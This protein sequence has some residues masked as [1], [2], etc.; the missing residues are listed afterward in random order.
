MPP[1]R[2]SRLILLGLFCATTV[3]FAQTQTQPLSMQSAP[4]LMAK[5][6]LGDKKGMAVVG[7][8]RD[9]KMSF[10]SA[11]QALP[12]PGAAQPMFEIGSISKVFTGLLL[13]QAVERGELSLSDTLGKLLGDQHKLPAPVAAVTLGQLITHTSCLPR[14]PGDFFNAGIDEGNPYAAYDRERMWRALTAVKLES[15]APCEAVYSNYGVALVGELLSA[16]YNKPWETLVRERITGPLGMNDTMA[17]LGARAARLVPSYAGEKDAKPWDMP[18]FVGAGGLRSTAPDMLKFSAA[19]L[20]GKAGPLGA[21]A[22]RMLQPLAKYAG[23]EIGYAIMLRGAK[24]GRI[25]SHSGG[26]GGFRSYWMIDPTTRESLIAMASNDKSPVWGLERQLN[27]EKFKVETKEVAI[28]AASLPAYAG[29]YRIDKAMALTFV[30]QDGKLYGRLTGQAFEAL[31]PTGKD[32]FAFPAYGALFTF[33]R[34]GDK[35]SAVKLAQNGGVLLGKRSADPVPARALVPATE[36]EAY[37]GRYNLAAPGAP[38]MDFLVTRHHGALA[39]KLGQQDRYPVFPV[40]GKPDRFAYDI[41]QAQLQFERDASGKV[42]ALVLHQ[43]GVHRVARETGVGSPAT[44][45]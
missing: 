6:A 2:S 26:T 35:V 38:A 36:Q 7:I 37:L 12:G 29:L 32:T 13:A 3:C 18:A 45:P 1:S 19:I 25:Y 10:G 39:V 27:M 8:L 17:V 31:T 11:G 43:N 22:E 24:E 34:D 4:D 5:A 28:D 42:T 41:V 16:R 30:P 44:T 23:H 15:P 14:L 33:A 40:E 9:G 21:P 20:A